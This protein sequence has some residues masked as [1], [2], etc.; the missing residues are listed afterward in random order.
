MASLSTRPPVQGEQ[1]DHAQL[2]DASMEDGEEGAPS[3]PPPAQL[4][5]GPSLGKKFRD[6][7]ERALGECPKEIMR[8]DEDT[9]LIRNNEEFFASVL[10][11]YF[12]GL[13]GANWTLWVR[14][15]AT[16]Q[17]PSRSAQSDLET[18]VEELEDQQRTTSSELSLVF[19]CI[20]MQNQA[21]A[22]AGSGPSQSGPGSGHGGIPN[23][24]PPEPQTD[25][26]GLEAPQGVLLDIETAPPYHLDGA[27]TAAAGQPTV[28]QSPDH[29][30]GADLGIPQ[31]GTYPDGQTTPGGPFQQPWLLGNDSANMPQAAGTSFEHQRSPTPEGDAWQIVTLAYF[32][33]YPNPYASHVLACDVISRT[34]TEEGTL[35]TTRLIKKTGAVPK[36]FPKQFI[37]RAETWVVEESEVDPEGRVV[38]STTRNLD[39][40]KIMQVQ[41]DV[42][43]REAEDGSTVQ[44]VTANVVSNFGWGLT[45]KIEKYGVNKFKSN[46]ERSRQGISLVLQAVREHRMRLQG[47][48]PFTLGMVAGD[49]SAYQSQFASSSR[50]DQHQHLLIDAQL[51]SASNS[52]SY[53]D[54]RIYR[55]SSSVS[56]DAASSSSMSPASSPRKRSWLPQWLSNRIPFGSARREED[57]VAAAPLPSSIGSA[58]SSRDHDPTRDEPVPQPP[59][60]SSGL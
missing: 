20:A 32:L 6:N 56:S 58:A 54:H 17:A 43:L 33:R 13:K 26:H 10:G 30:F 45:K 41:E 47:L 7:L 23:G 44:R 36:W 37:S 46:L 18:R 40:V 2:S 59:P 24:P 34:L 11:K 3:N 51:E 25:A 49:A 31:A 50:A 55:T 42:V 35:K 8:L 60:S 57:V 4:T 16:P 9:I 52:P 28:P 12:V 39:H 53:D 48:Q 22:S 14:G 21:V 1:S 38:Q 5:A 15:K 29:G 19:Q 27:P